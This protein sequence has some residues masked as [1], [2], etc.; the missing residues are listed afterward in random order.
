M[1]YGGNDRTLGI[2]TSVPGDGG[3]DG[4]IKED[5]LGLEQIYIQAKRYPLQR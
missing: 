4:I 3:I 1:G 5:K 2:H